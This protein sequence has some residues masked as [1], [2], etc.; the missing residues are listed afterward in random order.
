[1]FDTCGQVRR[2]RAR[3]CIDPDLAACI[4]CPGIEPR[5]ESA[6]SCRR[7]DVGLTHRWVTLFSVGEEDRQVVDVDEEVVELRG[8]PSESSQ[9]AMPGRSGSA[10]PNTAGMSPDRS[11]SNAGRVDWSASVVVTTVVPEPPL[12]A[13][14]SVTI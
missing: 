8:A 3:T 2:R 5:T 10:M 1:M 9:S 13:Q 14:Q 11:T 12:A 6:P 7:G 4:L